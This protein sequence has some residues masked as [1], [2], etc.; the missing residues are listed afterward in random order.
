MGSGVAGQRVGARL[1]W[2]GLGKTAVT[3]IALTA[4]LVLRL[5]RQSSFNLHHASFTVI[6]LLAVQSDLKDAEVR[7]RGCLLTAEPR[8]LKLTTARLRLRMT[9]SKR[10]RELGKEKPKE[11]EQVETLRSLVQQKLANS[12]R[13]LTR[14]SGSGVESARVVIVRTGRVKQLADAIRQA[15]IGMEQEK[16][17]TAAFPACAERC[18][19]HGRNSLP[20]FQNWESHTLGAGDFWKSPPENDSAKAGAPVPVSVRS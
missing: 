12:R 4:E 18:L 16:Q 20:T 5:E 1:V 6:S 2:L 17:G 11:R 3:L 9:N 15:I 19:R 14:T 10:V 7:E 8:Y 13:A